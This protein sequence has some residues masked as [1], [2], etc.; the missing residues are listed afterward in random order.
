MECRKARSHFTLHTLTSGDDANGLVRSL[1][2]VSSRLR[3]VRRFDAAV[4][5]QRAHQLG[6]SGLCHGWAAAHSSLCS[7]EQNL[8]S[9]P[10][11]TPLQESTRRAVF[12][13]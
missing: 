7:V 1:H 10:N 12:P 9:T 2:W 5:A 11:L 3:E 13:Q 6:L 8:T 4:I